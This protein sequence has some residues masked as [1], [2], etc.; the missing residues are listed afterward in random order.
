MTDT[1]TRFRLPEETDRY[2]WI[3]ADPTA[4]P[5]AACEVRLTLDTESGELQVNFERQAFGGDTMREVEGLDVSVQL[6]KTP[7]AVRVTTAIN[8]GKFDQLLE[9]MCGDD[10]L[11]AWRASSELEDALSDYELNEPQAGVYEAG[12]WLDGIDP[13]EEYGITADSSEEVLEAIASQI[14][15][16]A[17]QDCGAVLVGTLAHLQWVREQLQDDD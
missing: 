2:A 8:A 17:Y 4:S 10:D 7:D 14:E 1:T 13:A 15:A 11:D 6:P 5:A 3:V 16:E 9:R 12:F